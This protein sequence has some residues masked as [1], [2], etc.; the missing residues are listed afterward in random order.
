MLQTAILTEILVFTYSKNIKDF[1][2]KINNL[3][4]AKGFF[5]KKEQIFV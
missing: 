1:K 4:K 5:S 3:L 2:N